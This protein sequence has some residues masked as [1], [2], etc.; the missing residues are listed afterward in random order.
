MIV[1][2]SFWCFG[3]RSYGKTIVGLFGNFTTQHYYGNGLFIKCAERSNVNRIVVR[4]SYLSKLSK[5]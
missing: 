2:E 3:S 1:E 4:K 5:R